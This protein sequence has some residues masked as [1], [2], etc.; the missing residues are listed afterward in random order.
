MAEDALVGIIGAGPAGIAAGVQLKRFDI[1]PVVFERD[2]IGGLVRNA[3]RIENS[4][5]FPNGISGGEFVEILKEY[6][7]RYSLSIRQ[8]EV[9]S[10]KKEENFRVLTDKKE[11][12]FRYLI[13]ATGTRPR[14]LPYP[15]IEYHVTDQNG[16]YGKVLIV[17]G[18]DIAFDYALTMSEL[19]DEVIILYR[20]RV[21]ALPALR[22]LV[23]GRGIRVIKGEILNVSGDE[24]RTTAGEFEVDRIIAAIGRVP[25][26]EI[27]EGI[28]DAQMFIIGYAKN[29]PYRQ[30]TMAIGDG[31]KAAMD[32]WR[33]ENE[34]S[35]RD[36]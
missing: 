23:E 27:V 26:T 33:C 8:E 3:Y 28:T 5:F 17:G 11:Y 18:G 10:V 32:I 15:G 25:N 7:D 31:I 21:R 6:A 36:R 4:M 19:S 12:A 34:G 2:R 24:V 13:V 35:C 29:A 14:P 20:S 22:R 16:K 30:T 1:D 9:K